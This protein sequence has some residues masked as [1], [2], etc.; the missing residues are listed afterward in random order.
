[1]ELYIQFTSENFKYIFNT[2][3]LIKQVSLIFLNKNRVD[4]YSV[5]HTVIDDI[6]SYLF[7]VM[8]LKI[9]KL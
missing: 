4:S 2:I 3:N 5:I 7:P 1:M 8:Y 6:G 9:V